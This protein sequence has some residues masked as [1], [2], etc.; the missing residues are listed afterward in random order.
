MQS[1]LHQ[2]FRNC[3]LRDY[4]YRFLCNDQN[5]VNIFYAKHVHV[6]FANLVYWFFFVITNNNNLLG[7]FSFRNIYKTC[8][9]LV[10][11]DIENL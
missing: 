4:L 6:Q 10:D 1:D 8:K 7:N 3:A 11:T 5:F 2:V 9:L